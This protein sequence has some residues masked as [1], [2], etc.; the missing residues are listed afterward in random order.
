[1]ALKAKKIAA[2]RA[3]YEA[4]TATISAIAKKHKVAKTTVI[5]LAKRHGWKRGKNYRK[6]TSAIE[7]KAEKKF[8]EEESDRLA[9]FTEKHIADIKTIRLLTRLNLS[10]VAL[11]AKEAKESGSS[12]HKEITENFFS[13][14][15]VMKIASETLTNCYREE[16]LAMGLGDQ[17]GIR[18]IHELS[19]DA[20]MKVKKLFDG[21]TE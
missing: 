20:A 21:I 4:G 17:A 13:F 5:Y 7:K 1:M 14:Q 15:K 9:Q 11:A 19:E 10:D 6:T 8:I 2:I 18:L 12:L 16:R 3:K